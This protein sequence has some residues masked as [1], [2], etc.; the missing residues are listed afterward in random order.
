MS[1]VKEA[2]EV[3]DLY[4]IKYNYYLI[5]SDEQFKRISNIT[6]FKT[7]PQIFIKDK[8]IGGYSELADLCTNGN[9]SI[10]IN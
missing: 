2:L 6:S 4:N 7:F 9:L 5:N 1:L 8:F 3:L 10:H